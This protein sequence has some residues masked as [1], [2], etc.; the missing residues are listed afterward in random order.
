MSSPKFL[1]AKRELSALRAGQQKLPRAKWYRQ[2]SK[3]RAVLSESREYKV[4]RAKVIVRADGV[5]ER[6]GEDGEHVHHIIAVYK[7]LDLCVD[8][9]NGEYLCAGCHNDEH[10]GKLTRRK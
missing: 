9:R 4:F 2:W 7:D 10:D 3:W 8:E 6:C 1:R 5:C